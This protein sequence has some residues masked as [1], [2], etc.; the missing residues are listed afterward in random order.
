MGI[1]NVADAKTKT[2]LEKLKKLVIQKVMD[3]EILE[4]YDK[5]ALL[6]ELGLI[7][8]FSGEIEVTVRYPYYDL[9]EYQ[10]DDLADV[11]ISNLNEYQ[12]YHHPSSGDL[13]YD[14][15]PNVKNWGYV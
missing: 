2:E 8:T 13:I 1:V 14:G 15:S 12:V 6:A 5:N 10:R 7:Q 3:S 9:S 4:D 11:I